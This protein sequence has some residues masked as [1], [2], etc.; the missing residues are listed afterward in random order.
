MNLALSVVAI[1]LFFSFLRFLL[2]YGWSPTHTCS[3]APRIAHS[4]VWH[5]FLCRTCSSR[6]PN[7]RRATRPQTRLARR[8]TSAGATRCVSYGLPPLLLL[9][10]Q[11]LASGFSSHAPTAASLS[12]ALASRRCGPEHGQACQTSYFLHYFLTLITLSS[13]RT[14][15][16]AL[17]IV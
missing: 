3:H 6:C 15:A 1:G 12:C 14:S 9:P 7:M 13:C 8:G 16:W 10:L 17:T 5:M 2:G 11:L 4:F